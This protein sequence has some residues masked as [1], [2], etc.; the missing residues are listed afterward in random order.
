MTNMMLN[1]MLPTITAILM[2]FSS[3]GPLTKTE[4]K[5]QKSYWSK[6]Q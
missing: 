2:D 1:A 6:K 3:C 4:E 5:Q